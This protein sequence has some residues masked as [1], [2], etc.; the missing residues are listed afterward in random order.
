MCVRGRE[1][2]NIRSCFAGWL[3]G[4]VQLSQVCNEQNL[5][6]WVELMAERKANVVLQLASHHL[7]KVGSLVEWSWRCQCPGQPARDETCNLRPSKLADH[8]R[9]RRDFQPNY[10]VHFNQSPLIVQSGG[11]IVK[12]EWFYAGPNQWVLRPQTL[13]A[14]TN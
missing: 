5:F 10:V 7:S 9:F 2:S 4:C 3:I 14:Y 12:L 13:V 6:Q 8:Y 11:W 1:M